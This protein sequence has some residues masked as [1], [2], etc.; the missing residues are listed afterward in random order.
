MDTF[1][2]LRGYL[3]DQAAPIL[4]YFEAYIG[5]PRPDGDGRGNPLFPIAMWNVHVRTLEDRPRT[6]NNLEG[7]HRRFQAYIGGQHPNLWRFLDVLK[8]EEAVTSVQIAQMVAGEQAPAQRRVYRNVRQRIL[9]IVQDYANRDRI[10]FLRGIAYNL[11]TLTYRNLCGSLKCVQ[12]LI[13]HDYTNF[14]PENLI[15]LTVG[16]FILGHTV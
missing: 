13:C 3:P 6:N 16:G 9:T 14:F 2:I 12:D 4:D 8:R 15:G 10:V 11:G 5:R 7:W 1:E